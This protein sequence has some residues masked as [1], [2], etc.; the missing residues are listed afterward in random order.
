MLVIIQVRVSSYCTLDTNDVSGCTNNSFND[1]KGDAEVWDKGRPSERSSRPP[2]FKEYVNH[3]VLEDELI[4]I[5]M[6]KDC[7]SLSRVALD[8][9]VEIRVLPRDNTQKR[10]I[11]IFSRTATAASQ[12]RAQLEYRL[13]YVYASPSLI[14][15]SKRRSNVWREFLLFWGVA[16]IVA[17]NENAEYINIGGSSESLMCAVMTAATRSNFILAEENLDPSSGQAVFVICAPKNKIGAVIQ[18]LHESVDEGGRLKD[19]LNTEEWYFKNTIK[20]TIQQYYKYTPYHHSRGRNNE[21]PYF[22]HRQQ[23]THYN[24]YHHRG[25]NGEKNLL[26]KGN[27]DYYEESSDEDKI[28]YFNQVENNRRI[29]KTYNT[30]NK[31]SNL[32]DGPVREPII[33]IKSNFAGNNLGKSRT[34]TYLNSKRLYYG[35]HEKID[36]ATHKK[37]TKNVPYLRA[38]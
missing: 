19:E 6:G 33:S 24:K 8:Y 30:E 27:N 36:A 29:E 32:H 22:H 38:P 20:P 4:G 11:M 13:G 7:T 31:D 35:R 10:A 18:I 9:N 37:N 3:F 21:Q 17:V 26:K 2:Y 16:A 28:K 34:P 15:D 5:A 1:E 25:Y 23:Q 14:R 12:A